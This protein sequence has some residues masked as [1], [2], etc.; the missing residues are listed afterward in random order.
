MYN[1]LSNLINLTINDHVG[2]F[3]M[4]NES[5]TYVYGPERISTHRYSPCSTVSSVRRTFCLIALFDLCFCFI[6]WVIYTQVRVRGEGQIILIS[7]CTV[8]YILLNNFKWIKKFWE[9]NEKT[10]ILMKM[11]VVY[12][13]FSWLAQRLFGRPLN[14]KLQI[15]NFRPLCLIQW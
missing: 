5:Y 4:E 8:L 1:H 13:C 6:L 12:V 11:F 10:W 9:W 15:I 2:F 14:N 3:R 7:K